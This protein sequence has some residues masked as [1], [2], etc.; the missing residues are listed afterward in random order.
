MPQHI[1]VTG[2]SRSGKS[3]WAERLAEKL[4]QP[5]IYVATALENPDDAE[6]QQRIEQHRRRRPSHWQT[7]SV[8]YDLCATIEQAKPPHCLLIDSLGTWVANGLEQD[9]ETWQGITTRL[10][11]STQQASVDLIFVAE[12]TGWGV[13]PAYPLGRLFR[14]RLGHLIRQL[15]AI[16]NTT[17]LVTGGHVLNLS[18][19]GEPLT[20][21]DYD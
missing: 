13:V 18:L 9:N 11:K 12:E 8:S 10:L 17:Y 3:E 16:A 14:D 7:L 15:G 21:I 20:N 5:V 19:L 2:P 4:E 1:L 6:W